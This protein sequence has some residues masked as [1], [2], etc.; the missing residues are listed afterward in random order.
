[1][2][3][4]VEPPSQIVD[5]SLSINRLEASTHERLHN[6]VSSKNSASHHCVI[7]RGVLKE[8]R[9]LVALTLQ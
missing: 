7:V 5:F 2:R 6:R 1:M 8:R 4:V 3:G 9:R